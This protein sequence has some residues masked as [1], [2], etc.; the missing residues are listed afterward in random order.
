MV[1]QSD[2]ADYLRA[3]IET[4]HQQVRTLLD[5]A[6]RVE[7][8]LA[9][10]TSQESEKGWVVQECHA[11]PL[12]SLSVWPM[13]STTTMGRCREAL[14]RIGHE[15]TA[16]EISALI[17]HQFGAEPA[18]STAEMLR[19]RSADARSGIYRIKCEGAPARYGLSLW[20]E[21]GVRDINGGRAA[22]DEAMP[23]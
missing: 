23:A 20:K 12:K 13:T 2:F 17:E 9:S 7:A 11:E 6:S 3:E 21:S 15:A 18:K 22:E 5:R 16:R 14:Q 8:M 10:S 1:L 4:I 19:K